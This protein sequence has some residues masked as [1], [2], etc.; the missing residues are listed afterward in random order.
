MQLN[1]AVKIRKCTFTTNITNDRYILDIQDNG[2]GISA[3]ELPYIFDR[4]YR[5]D[6]ARSRESGG[7]GLGLSIAKQM[8]EE[9]EGTIHA[10]S[11]VGEGTKISLVIPYI[12]KID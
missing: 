8:I 1:I 10:N 12:S 6:K 11:I 4:F 7:S 5:V 9:Y 3:E 2:V